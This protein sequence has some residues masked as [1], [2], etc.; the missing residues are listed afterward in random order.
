MARAP[1]ADKTYGILPRVVDEV[2]GRDGSL[3]TP[4]R[5][6]WTLANLEELERRYT[7]QPDLRVDIG[8]E[9]K[10]KG[11]LSG[12]PSD[13]VQLMAEVHYLYYVPARYNIGGAVKRARTAE[14]LGWMEQP[15]AIPADL[16]AV[17]DEG[18]G[19]GGPAFNNKK[20]PIF[21]QE[22]RY[23][24]AWKRLPPGDRAAALADPWAFKAF[25]AGVPLEPGGQY[26]RESLLHIVFPD[27]FER[28]FSQS[29][30]WAQA[31]TFGLALDITDDDV[32][33][34]LWNI[35]QRLGESY[36][37][38]FD[39]YESIPVRALWKPFDDPWTAFVY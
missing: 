11:Q 35:R 16:D 29:D 36:G 20:W 33:R 22:L 21:I 18:I 8:F 3:F 26:A 19:S 23:A 13:V 10:L 28:T 9:E 39:F 1:R 12:A 25:I 7:D 32:D 15:V 38:G 4:D 2:L 6:I 17:L 31:N 24:V 34:R 27:F 30:K 5:A 14:I 37:P